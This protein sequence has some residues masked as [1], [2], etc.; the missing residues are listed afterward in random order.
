MGQGTVSHAAEG[1]I[2]MLFESV[3]Q[4]ELSVPLLEQGDLMSVAEPDRKG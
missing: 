2:V 1:R 4:K 3:G